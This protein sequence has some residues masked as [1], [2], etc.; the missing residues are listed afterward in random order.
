MNCSSKLTEP[1]ERVWGTSNLPQ[2]GQKSEDCLVIC[3][4]PSHLYGTTRTALRNLKD[5]PFPHFYSGPLEVYMD[6]Y[7]L[8]GF[9][10]TSFLKE[11]SYFLSGLPRPARGMCLSAQ[12]T[13]RI[14]TPTR[15]CMQCAWC[16]ITGDDCT[17]IVDYFTGVFL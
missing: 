3:G 4:K 1:K 12:S 14:S 8:N 10:S 15:Q 5:L 17:F 7:P 11:N 6:M 13:G 16:I 2:V 9:W